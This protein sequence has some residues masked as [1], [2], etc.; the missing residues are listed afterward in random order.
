MFRSV[1][2]FV[3]LFVV[4]VSVGG[5]LANQAVCPS[6][7]LP[8]NGA[9]QTNLLYK[10]KPMYVLDARNVKDGYLPGETYS[11]YVKAQDSDRKFSDVMVWAEESGQEGCKTGSFDTNPE[12]YHQPENCSHLVTR[13]SKAPGHTFHFSWTAPPCG[14]VTIRARVTS[15][16]SGSYVLDDNSSKQGYLTSYVCPKDL[17]PL[18]SKIPLEKRE[19]LLCRVVT[20]MTGSDIATRQHV[21]SR[22][23]MEYNAMSPLQKNAWEEALGQ[24]AYNIKKCCGL[25]GIERT[26]CLGDERRRRIDRFCA[27]GESM[28]PYTVKRRQFMAERREECCWRLGERRYHC[29]ANIPTDSA[30]SKDSVWNI[31]HVQEMDESDPI[32][33][34]EDY[35][36]EVLKEF[37]SKPYMVKATPEKAVSDDSQIDTTQKENTLTSKK[38]MTTEAHTKPT[39]IPVVKTTTPPTTTTT[40]TM[41]TKTTTTTT[42]IPVTTTEAEMSKK[43]T[44]TSADLQR[45]MKKIRLRLDCCESGREEGENVG[46][47]PWDT[48]ASRSYKY[49]RKMR[50]ARRKCRT[51]FL[52]CCIEE[53][54]SDEE[55][56][57]DEDEDDD[58]SDDDNRREQSEIKNKKE[59]DDNEDDDQNDKPDDE[60]KQKKKSHQ[61]KSVRSNSRSRKDRRRVGRK[62]RR[63]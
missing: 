24:R 61:R 29:F 35:N 46:D 51:Y 52:K 60:A 36:A 11:L 25:R 12:F 63:G 55:I 34:L 33:D 8:A 21:L 3:L 6:V 43:T 58:D 14:C 32:N 9:R 45:K 13:N 17:Q 7:G 56:D 44:L 37:A 30:F 26:E 53:A 18:L 40:T 23:K 54:E 49:T 42:E 5:T 50:K 47:N 4:D 2:Q 62:H 41:T 15:V 10:T 16:E 22:R 38:L 48:C 57:I 19:N 27:F 59:N 20:N 39:T 31:K 1:L 28:I